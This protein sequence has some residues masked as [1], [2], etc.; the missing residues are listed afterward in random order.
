[1]KNYDF[2]I[3]LKIKQS[4]NI[5]TTMVSTNSCTVIWNSIIEIQ[6]VMQLPFL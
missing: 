3:F 6:F 5:L 1:L 4:Q 2:E